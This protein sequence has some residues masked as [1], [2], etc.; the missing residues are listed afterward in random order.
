M[1]GAFTAIEDTRTVR[2][3]FLLGGGGEP[4]VFFWPYFKG[5]MLRRHPN[6]DE[7]SGDV[8]V[9]SLAKLWD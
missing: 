5:E 2:G 3:G 7:C 1:V 9:Y 4:K 6:A 8:K